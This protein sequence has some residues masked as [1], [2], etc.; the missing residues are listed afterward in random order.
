MTK[1]STNSKSD[2]LVHLG[3]IISIILIF[4]F[5]FF[6][7][8]LPWRTNHGESVKV[9]DLKGLSF[10]DAENALESLDLNYEISDS[11]FVSGAK[12]LSIL[13]NYPKSGANVKVGRK[14]Y[15]TVA[16]ISAPMVKMPN[17][18]G[19][20]TSSAQNQLLSS[21][22][23]Y[24]GE[25]QIAALEENTVLK[26]KVNGKEI[27]QGSDVPKGSKVIL[28]VGDGYGNQ[29]ID[30]PS[31]IGMAQDE[32]D[33]FLSGLGLSVG[34]VIYEVSE[35]PAGTVIKQRPESIAGEKIKIGS[36]VNIWVSGEAPVN[37]TIENP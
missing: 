36:P 14:I 3:I 32:A 26:I 23:I 9:P 35:K 13:S 6:F 7:I 31:V 25:E 27:E 12:P 30:V 19:R 16:A 20:S 22:L 28:V 11:I 8:Y 17:I 2:I 15:L 1:Y 37:A 24:G 4:F 10:D 5:T 29:R 33:I 21:G 18:I 34:A